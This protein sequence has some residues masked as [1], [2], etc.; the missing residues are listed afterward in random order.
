MT[1]TFKIQCLFHSLFI[2]DVTVGVGCAHPFGA[3]G[4][5]FFS[6]VRLVFPLSCSMFGL[7][8]NFVFVIL[9]LFF[10]STKIIILS[11][12]PFN[13]IYLQFV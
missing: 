7:F 1:R 12:N 3:I 2:L 4:L 5:T 9:N 13:H 6:G 10:V 11:Y 8:V